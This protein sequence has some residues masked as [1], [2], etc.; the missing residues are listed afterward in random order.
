MLEVGHTHCP[1]DYRL[2]SEPV[3]FVAGKAETRQPLSEPVAG[4]EQIQAVNSV[5]FSI[6]QLQTSSE[7]PYEPAATLQEGLCM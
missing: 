2:S 7:V 6:I 5:S 3:S 4:T 1:P